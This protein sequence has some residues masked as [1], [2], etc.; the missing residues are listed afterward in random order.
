MK[1][2]Q[3]KVIADLIKIK[4]NLLHPLEI[5]PRIVSNNATYHVLETIIAVLMDKYEINYRE[6]MEYLKFNSN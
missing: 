5:E 4:S 3:I 2:T 6:I 1:E